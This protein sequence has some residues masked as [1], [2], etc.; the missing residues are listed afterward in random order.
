MR[1]AISIPQYVDEGG[2][3]PDRFRAHLQRA[4]ELGFE[5]GW[6]QEQVLGSARTLSPLET[7]TFAAACVER[8]RLGCAVFVLPLHNPLH[9]AKA[10]TSLD[11]LSRGRAEVGVVAGGRGRP[12]AAFGVDDERPVARFNE[13]VALMKACWTESEVNFDGEFWKLEHVSMEPKP[14]QDPHPPLWLGGNHPNAL[15]RA[16]RLGDGFIGAGSQTSA[17]FAEQVQMVRR[18]LSEQGRDPTSFQ[19]AKRV[20]IHVEDDEAAARRRIGEALTRHYW[21]RTGLEAMAVAGPPGV[22]V[23]GLR[24]VVAA[25]AELI[26]LNTLVDDEQQMERLS[27]EVLPE[28]QD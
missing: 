5:S 14:V 24:E 2:F 9:L 27:A 22:C 21:G 19:I 26:L 25:G 16:A 17:A 1:F 18:E 11:R 7:L 8:L 15:R 28:L 3:D 4:E 6:T 20:Y 12:F 13:A 23:D 10:I